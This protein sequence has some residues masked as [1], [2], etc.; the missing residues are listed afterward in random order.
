M[1]ESQYLAVCI[2]ECRVTAEDEL[3][4]ATLRTNGERRFLDLSSLLAEEDETEFESLDIAI[5]MLF[6]AGPHSY[7]IT[8]DI[9]HAVRSAGFDGIIYPSYFSLVRT[10]AMPFETVFG[11]SRRRIPQTRSFEDA[12][13]VRNVAIF[14]RPIAEQIVEVHSINKL[15][16]R[17]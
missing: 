3:Y 1:Y 11:I 6:L 16:I 15:I 9:A 14:G 7:E 5:H 10:G 12:K 2:H 13:I 8:R 4:V 17:R